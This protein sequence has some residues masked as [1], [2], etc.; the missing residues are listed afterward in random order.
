MPNIYVKIFYQA[1]SFA[2]LHLAS[3]KLGVCVCSSFIK[4]LVV[5]FSFYSCK[6]ELISWCLAFLCLL[7]RGKNTKADT[8][9]IPNTLFLRFLSLQIEPVLIDEIGISLGSGPDG[10]RA[11]FRDIE[12]FGVSNLTL[13]NVRYVNCVVKLLMRL[14]SQTMTVA[15]LN[16]HS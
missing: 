1:P 14:R 7:E 9:P 10:Y 15:R 2:L 8:K 4:M 6:L 13:T 11:T 12:A 3:S 5:S 16:A